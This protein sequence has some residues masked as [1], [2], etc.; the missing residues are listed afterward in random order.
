MLSTSGRMAARAS[1][2]KK[3]PWTLRIRCLRTA[4]H[5]GGEPPPLHASW[6]PHPASGCRQRWRRSW[7]CRSMVV[8]AG[9][10]E[11]H[12]APEWGEHVVDER[13]VE[14]EVADVALC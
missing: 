11:E 10:V 5:G 2:S 3:H 12:G 14:E 7:P 9:R 8:A 1:W 13:V 4:A 6:P